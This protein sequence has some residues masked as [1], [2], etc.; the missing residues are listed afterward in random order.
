MRRIKNKTILTGKKIHNLV[1]Q[2]KLKPS[3]IHKNVPYFAQWESR[4][5]VEPII[6]KKMKAQDDPLWKNSGAANKE[7]YALWSWSGCGMACLRMILGATKHKNIPLVTLAKQC[8]AR[9]V[10]REPLETS[11]GL[12][13]KPFVTF[14]EEEF[15]WRAKAVATLTH[16]KA[17]QTLSAGGYVIASVTPEIRHPHKKPVR[18]GGHLV[19]MLGY[20]DNKK[21]FYLHNPS[22]FIASQE[23]FEI[24][25][26][27]FTKFFSHKGILVF[28]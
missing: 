9:G 2:H 5:L 19:L 28:T 11:P 25:Y 17:K 18:K 15:G 20:D 26:K 6:T 22:G 3:Y 13:Y 24:S 7:E 16:L 23:Y 10:Y 4:E 27:D 12:F 1:W 8:L 21:L 14:V